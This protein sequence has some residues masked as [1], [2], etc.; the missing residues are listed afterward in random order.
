MA[1]F[2]NKMFVCIVLWRIR[3][4]ATE[5][6]GK[7]RLKA[8]MK[9]KKNESPFARQRLATTHSRCTTYI[10]KDIPVTTGEW[11]LFELVAAIRS[12]RNYRRDFIREFNS[13]IDSFVREFRRQFNSWVF[14]CGV[15]SSGQRKL[16]WPTRKS[17]PS[18]SRRT[19]DTHS[20][21][22]NG[23]S[24]RQSLIMSCHNWL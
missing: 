24:R 15:L 6:L 3:P 23:A 20:P 10:N 19:E 12:S 8:G 9:K 5:R 11:Q 1:P 13:V 22:R 2:H 4:F 18:Q 17:E 14:S 21:T 16:K 7:H